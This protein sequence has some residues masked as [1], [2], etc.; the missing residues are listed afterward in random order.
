MSLSAQ[1]GSDGHVE[2][3]SRR[4]T[5]LS[6]ITLKLLAPLSISVLFLKPISATASVATSDTVNLLA[7]ST[8]A[9]T[10]SYHLTRILFLRMLA[11]VYTAA[12]S[13]AK[14]QNKGLI[15]DRGE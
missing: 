14:F 13:V 7:S 3:S 6:S 4:S 11:I 10:P 5:P 12:F 9:I 15:G 2:T 8:T 1:N